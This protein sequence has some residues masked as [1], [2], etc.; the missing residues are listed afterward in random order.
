MRGVIGSGQPPF[1]FKRRL[2]QGKVQ[3]DPVAGPQK[4][5]RNIALAADPVFEVRLGA[6]MAAKKACMP[7][8]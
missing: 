2:L 3:P 4:S 8:I 6:R 1:F 5:Q 7:L